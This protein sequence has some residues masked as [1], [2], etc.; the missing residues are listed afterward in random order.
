MTRP[1]PRL[2]NWLIGALL[3]IGAVGL[4]TVLLVASSRDAEQPSWPV[5]PTT[6]YV[7][8]R[9]PDLTSPQTAQTADRDVTEVRS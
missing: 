7:P 1:P 8:V 5:A 4:L 9:P 3:L 2:R 6:G